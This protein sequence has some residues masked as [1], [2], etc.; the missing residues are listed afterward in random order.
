MYEFV[1]FFKSEEIK[2]QTYIYHAHSL[3][4]TLVDGLSFT[5]NNP[6]PVR[7]CQKTA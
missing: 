5:K 1:P 7:S 2:C 3:A 4:I 6:N